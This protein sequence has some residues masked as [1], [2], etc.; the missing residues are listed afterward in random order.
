MYVDNILCRWRLDSKSNRSSPSRPDL[1]FLADWEQKDMTGWSKKKNNKNAML[2]G[3][4]KEGKMDK[5]SICYGFF[6]SCVRISLETGNHYTSQRQISIA[7]CFLSHVYY[8]LYCLFTWK[9][10]L[11]TLRTLSA[12]GFLLFLVLHANYLV[13]LPR[14]WLLQISPTIKSV[15]FCYCPSAL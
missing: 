10:L 11:L 15:P 12:T 3:R 8:Y 7:F 9:I 1:I 5:K 2:F 6:V 4:E 14:I 13:I